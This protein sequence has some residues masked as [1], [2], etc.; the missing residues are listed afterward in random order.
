[1]ADKKSVL[2]VAN[3]VRRWYDKGDL[4]N[5]LDCKCAIVSASLSVALHRKGIKHRIHYA[6][7]GWCHVFVVV[8][9]YLLDLT[10]K[11]FD[12]DLEPIVFRRL[13][14]REREWYWKTTH[15]FANAKELVSFQHDMNWPKSQIH[16]KLG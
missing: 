7:D 6:G 13:K 5:S 16:P 3:Q 1:M 14:K 4:T 9:G 15:T 10:A 2:K 8:D 11:Q 12:D